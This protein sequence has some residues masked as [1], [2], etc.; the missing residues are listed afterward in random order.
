MITTVNGE[1]L[2]LGKYV[3]SLDL[4]GHDAYIYKFDE[5][6]SDLRGELIS[7]TG[8]KKAANWIQR[9]HREPLEHLPGIQFLVTQGPTDKNPSTGS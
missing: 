5:T 3:V 7:T 2:P 8:W 6:N 9:K 4:N 1:P